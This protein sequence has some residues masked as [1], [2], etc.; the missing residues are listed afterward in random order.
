MLLYEFS[1]LI[2][3]FQKHFNEFTTFIS[4]IKML[5]NEFLIPSSPFAFRNI[6]I[7]SFDVFVV[8]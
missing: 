7:S 4:F 1:A 2:A 6:L 5:A 8:V 3:L